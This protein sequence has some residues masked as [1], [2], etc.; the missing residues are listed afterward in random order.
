MLDPGPYLV[1]PKGKSAFV[2]L[3]LA[4]RPILA[5]PIVL[6]STFKPYPKG[7][8]IVSMP[9]EIVSNWL[10]ILT[11]RPEGVIE[12]GIAQAW[13]ILLLNFERLAGRFHAD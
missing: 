13:P 3:I 8:R 7:K 2:W 12:I 9:L 1:E 6:A 10:V 4:R 11:C 5:A